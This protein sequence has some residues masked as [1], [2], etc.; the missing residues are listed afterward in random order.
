VLGTP[1]PES[2]LLPGT[3][4]SADLF[5][6]YLPGI[7]EQARRLA[8]GDPLVEQLENFGKQWPLSCVGMRLKALPISIAAILEHP[9]LKQLYVDRIIE[10]RAY[11]WIENWSLVQAVRSSYGDHAAL[12]PDLA[13]AIHTIV[14]GQS[15]PPLPQTA[16]ALN[17]ITS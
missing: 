8:P 17:P 7:L 11:S 15:L 12:C 13:E 6:S 2:D 5:L 3:L 14:E 10:F 1:C 9:G 4:Y 16:P